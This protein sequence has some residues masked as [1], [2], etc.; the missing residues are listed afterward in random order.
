MS[1]A[2]GSDIRSGTTD[3]EYE[4]TLLSR[5][6][7]L[8]QRTDLELERSAFLLLGRL[9]LQSP[10]SLKELARAFSLDVSTVNRQVAA[11]LRQNL[12]ERVSDPE[13]GTARK[14]RPTDTGLAKL[15]ADRRQTVVGLEKVL[16]RWTPDERESL[17]YLLRRFNQSV[18][19]LEG[20]DWPRPGDR[21][22]PDQS[23]Q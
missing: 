19:H 16:A 20:R 12:V 15:H 18:E 7:A 2:K 23:A 17:A 11:L 14:I 10:M 8:A 1:K 9:E 5:Y 13:G 6:H 22:D 21:V 3:I 4:L